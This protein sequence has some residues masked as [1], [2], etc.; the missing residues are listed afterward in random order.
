MAPKGTAFGA[1]A[2][3]ALALVVAACAP[4]AAGPARSDPAPPTEAASP[5]ATEAATPAGTVA[6]SPSPAA[7][8]SLMPSATPAGATIRTKDS[9]GGACGAQGTALFVLRG[10]P[11]GNRAGE[12][13]WLE[14][15]FDRGK[16]AA[17]FPY[18]Y[19]ASFEPELVLRD[20]DG[21]VVATEGDVLELSGAGDPMAMCGIASVNGRP[22]PGASFAPPPAGSGTATVTMCDDQGTGI[23]SF[24]IEF[25]S[26]DRPPSDPSWYFEREGFD[27][28]CAP[29]PYALPAGR[30]DFW[31]TPFDRAFESNEGGRI[32][33][34]PGGSVERSLVFHRSVPGEGV[35]ELVLT[36]CSWDETRVPY[37]LTL[38]PL[39]GQA[40]A[41]RTVEPRPCQPVRH[42]LLSGRWRVDVTSPGYKSYRDVFS[43]PAGSET[44]GGWEF[45]PCAAS[46]CP[47]PEPGAP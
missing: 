34:A 10:S 4:S 8:P 31:V 14:P 45:V 13:V 42:R 41:P 33:V 26:R 6:P 24:R 7:S 1:L 3:G 22:V 20:G 30:W 28:D 36:V 39:D 46:G 2:L 12:K 35:G 11:T 23:G 40:P 9:P 44:S 16:L 37:T 18:A 15:D 29:R 17:I 5:A 47:T 38:T 32:E 21:V 43:V 27:G 19:T 25:R